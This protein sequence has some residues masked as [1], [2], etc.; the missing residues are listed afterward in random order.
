MRNLL[1]T[2]RNSSNKESFGMTNR[3]R[4]VV[5]PAILALVLSA[6]Y[7]DDIKNLFTQSF[8]M[9]FEGQSA[10]VLRRVP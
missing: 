3:E 7:C 4:M 1:S 9:G 10:S 2:F 5:Y 8:N 6:A